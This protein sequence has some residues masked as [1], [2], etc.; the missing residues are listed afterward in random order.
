MFA[1]RVRLHSFSGSNKTTSHQKACPLFSVSSGAGGG[2]AE[3]IDAEE[4]V[5]ENGRK[6]EKTGEKTGEK[7]EKIGENGKENGGENKKKREK[8]GEKTG[9]TGENGKKREKTRK[10]E[11]NGRVRVS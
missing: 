7:K 3:I 8:T 6:R 1:E 9:E 11:E 4:G 5:G 2:D 10:T